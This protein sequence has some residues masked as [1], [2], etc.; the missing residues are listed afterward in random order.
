MSTFYF[1]EEPIMFNIDWN[2]I[3]S[4]IAWP[5]VEALCSAARIVAVIAVVVALILIAKN[6]MEAQNKDQEKFEV[7]K[8]I[9]IVVAVFFI[10]W[11]LKTVLNFIGINANSF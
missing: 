7:L 2:S 8:K 3:W 6:Y 1:E 10:L 11:N 5:A 4:Q 9:A